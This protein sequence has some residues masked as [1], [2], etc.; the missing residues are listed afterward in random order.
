MDGIF[1]ILYFTGRLG[2]A[3]LFLVGILDSSFL[4]LPFGND[5]LILGLAS[6]KPVKLVWYA[7]CAALGSVTGSMLIDTLA[8]KG[9]E[10]GLCRILPAKR[11]ERVKRKVRTRAGYALAIA[12]LLPPPFPFTPFVAAAAALQFPRWKMIAV[13]MSARM[14]RFCIIGLLGIAFGPAI[15][16]LAELPEVKYTLLGLLAVCVVGSI[17]SVVGWVRRSRQVEA[18]AA[19]V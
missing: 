17:A 18:V 6:Q 5:L 8:R 1:S 3:G 16:R 10:R 9:G 2:A 15:H 12:A 11:I 13:L 14:L 19:S 7:F 4:F